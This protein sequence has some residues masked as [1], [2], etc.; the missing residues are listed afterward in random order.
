MKKMFLLLLAA[1][2]LSGC[3]EYKEKMKLNSDGSGEITYAIGI[4]ESLLSSDMNS[5]QLKDFDENKIKENYEQKK[6]IKILGT[7]SYSQDAIYGNSFPL[8]FVRKKKSG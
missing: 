2:F 3:L 7:T 4:S 6:G 1:I 5:A 8:L